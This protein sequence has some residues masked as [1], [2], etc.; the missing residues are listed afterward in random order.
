MT[1]RNSGGFNPMRHIASLTVLSLALA[2]ICAPFAHAGNVFRV[3]SQYKYW[4][5]TQVTASQ[6]A[7]PIT[8]YSSTFTIPNAGGINTYFVTMHATGNTPGGQ[9]QFLCAIDN[10][11]CISASA[12]T[13]DTGTPYIALLN[14]Q[15]P[16]AQPDNAITYS[17]CGAITPGTHTAAI[18][19]FASQADVNVNAL[20]IDID[21]A[22]LPSGSN[23]AVSH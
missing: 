14:N 4:D 2:I 21:V 20:R 7:Q 8:I 17:W 1:M 10:G 9:A 5:G 19:L 15:G 16:G 12:T 13:G 22:N 18:N 6:G 23:C 11:P 3:V